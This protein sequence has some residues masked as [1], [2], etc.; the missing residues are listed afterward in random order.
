M[1]Q[2]RPDPFLE[3]A[4]APA[5]H[6]LLTGRRFLAD[7]LPQRTDDERDHDAA[8]DQLIARIHTR[9]APGRTGLTGRRIA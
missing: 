2:R 3:H 4:R 7:V 1:S 9:Q 5:D 6:R 8:V